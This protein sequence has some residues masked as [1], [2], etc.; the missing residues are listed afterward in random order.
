MSALAS[1]AN[2]SNLPPVA[3]A[4]DAPA[5]MLEAAPVDTS[6]VVGGDA[7]A[8]REAAAHFAKGEAH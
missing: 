1:T 5:L 6:A 7:A 8:A 2:L 4:D 3:A